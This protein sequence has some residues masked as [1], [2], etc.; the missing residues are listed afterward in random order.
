M[1]KLCYE[2]FFVVEVF[3]VVSATT[4]AQ[5]EAVIHQCEN[6][7]WVLERALTRGHTL[8]PIERPRRD[9]SPHRCE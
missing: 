3:G 4:L 1:A 8:E 2:C 5:L 6:S 9:A 7:G